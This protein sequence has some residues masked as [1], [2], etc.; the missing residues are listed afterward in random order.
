[1]ATT[2]IS[3]YSG[4]P[5]LG[6]SV[7]AQLWDPAAGTVLVARSNGGIVED[8]TAN[9]RKVWT[10][11]SDVDRYLAFW[12]EGDGVYYQDVVVPRDVTNVTVDGGG[13]GGSGALPITGDGNADILGKTFLI[14]RGDTLPYLRRQ[15]VDTN[16][17]AVTLD[18]ADTVMFTMRASTDVAM[19]SG[20]KTHAA[21][22]IID[23]ALGIVEYRWV[24]A[25]TNTSTYVESST[26][27]RFTDTPYAAEFEV[28][29]ISDG[30]VETFPQADYIAISMPL[31]LDPGVNP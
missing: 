1:M 17:L 11:V 10:G 13:G 18:P 6:S 9:Y 27:G 4:T 16:G 5:A 20:A 31:D 8:K 15:L 23:S 29:R 28:T 3:T 21:A 2:V 14:K 24:S 22:V 30:K 25:D 19:A 7:F 26:L 12:D